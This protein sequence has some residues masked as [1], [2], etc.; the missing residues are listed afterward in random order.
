MKKGLLSQTVKSSLKWQSHREI[1]KKMVQ[2]HF[3]LT[4]VNQTEKKYIGKERELTKKLRDLQTKVH[5]NNKHM[6]TWNILAITDAFFDQKR[7]NVCEHTVKMASPWVTWMPSLPCVHIHLL[8]SDRERHLWSPKYFKF[9]CVCVLVY[10][11]LEISWFFWRVPFL[12]L[13]I[14]KHCAYD[15]T[16]KSINRMLLP[17]LN[18]K[19]WYTVKTS[20]T[21]F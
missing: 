2:R 6:V 10:F 16:W 20:K 15:H 5:T 18:D 1:I 7:I 8:S 11:R 21:Y 3:S 17:L 14:E 12:F 4:D 13:F 19:D 9:P